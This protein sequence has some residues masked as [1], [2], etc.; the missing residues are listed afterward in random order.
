[1]L[2]DGATFVT[3][4]STSI[5]S[6]PAGILEYKMKADRAGMSFFVHAWT[7]SFFQDTTFVQVAFQVNGFEDSELDVSERM[8]AY[9][10]LFNLIANS[11]VF[12]DKWTEY[13]KIM[14][15]SSSEEVDQTDL[16]YDD[17]TNMILILTVSFIVTWV[18]GL[19]PPLVVRYLIARR[20]LIKKTASWIAAGFSA[21]FWISFL[22]LNE[23]LGE[24]SGT[25]T[26][27]IIVF[28]VSRWIMS[29]GYVA[30]NFQ[31]DEVSA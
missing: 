21:F 30:K 8:S 16:K 10:P 17:N 19:A 28:F 25:G 24:E 22:L 15:E 18:L 9:K 26:V 29:R 6:I 11:I 12:P 31:S 27:W 3:A 23:T 5:E 4:Q 14:K 2:P 7:L 1:M 20:P 13:P